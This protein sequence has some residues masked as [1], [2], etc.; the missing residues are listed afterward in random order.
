MNYT[1]DEIC[2]A[3]ENSMRLGHTMNDTVR[4]KGYYRST[5]TFARDVLRRLK[6]EPQVTAQ[7]VAFKINAVIRDIGTV[8]V[9]DEGTLEGGE[10]ILVLDNGQRFRVSVTDLNRK[11]E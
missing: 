1:D 3:I 11:G 7:D 5:K 4:A 8:P 2:A 6:E 10:L 9:L